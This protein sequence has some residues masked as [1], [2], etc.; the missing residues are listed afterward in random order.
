MFGEI[1]SY[2]LSGALEHTL[3]AKSYLFCLTTLITD[4]SRILHAFYDFDN[5]LIVTNFYA[6]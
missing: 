1:P 3:K 2:H 4:L 6:I 5:V